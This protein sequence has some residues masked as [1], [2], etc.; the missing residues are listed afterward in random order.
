MKVPFFDFERE[1]DEVLDAMREACDR[2]LRSRR[3]IG[4]PEV[5]AFEER[6]AAY[7][8]AEHA[9]GVSSG[10]DALLVTLMA[11]GVGPGDEVILPDLTFFSPAGCVARLGATPVFVDIDADSFAI[12]PE[13]VEPAITE[14]TA[15][16]IAVHLFGQMADMQR[17]VDIGNSH[18]IPVIEDAAQAVGARQRGHHAGTLGIAGCFSF[19]P[20][21]NLGA[22]GDGGMVIT[23]D[24]ELADRIRLLK[25]H[26]ARPKYHHLEVG[27]NFRLD[28]IQAAILAVRLEHLERWTDL[29]RQN[30]RLYLELLDDASVV[31][32]N[33]KPYNGP[34]TY[35]Q[36]CIRSHE[37]DALKI[38]LQEAG[39]GTMIYY[40]ST[41]SD[42][43]AFDG[44]A[45]RST[46]EAHLTAAE[47]LALP[48]FPHLTPREIEYVA[49][50]TR[51][52]VFAA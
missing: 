32:P 7:S 21:K 25:N 49:D 35:H 36:F 12:L 26:G 19:Y 9:L 41:L 38:R 29:R 10:T 14:R 50:V 42:Q 11:L 17:L 5:A 52:C 8:A 20:T 33:T 2:V 40:P 4:G 43:P 47:I 6:F 16:I 48:I 24:D 23:D 46:P 51:E 22:A 37:R 28:A 18:E 13:A 45:K 31:L 30:A 27:G 1:D 34:H 15:A 39:I 44:L 3:Y